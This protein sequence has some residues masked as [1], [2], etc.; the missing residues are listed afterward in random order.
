M[1]HLPYPLWNKHVL[2]GIG[3]TNGRFVNVEADFHLLFDKRVA[4]IL[5]EMDISLGLRAEV[6]ILCNK[7]LLV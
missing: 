3:N 7:R 5:V 2:E 1:P 6:E 4:R